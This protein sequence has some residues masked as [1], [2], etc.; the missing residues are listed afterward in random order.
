MLSG[1]KGPFVPEQTHTLVC[2][3]TYI[4]AHSLPVH[5]SRE[6]AKLNAHVACLRR[7]K[8]GRLSF[9][10][11]LIHQ[12]QGTVGELPRCHKVTSHFVSR[13]NEMNR[14][15]VRERAAGFLLFRHLKNLDVGQRHLA[16]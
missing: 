8:P 15:Q 12:G 6:Q 2:T 14:A 16:R 3:H 1:D 7:G 5:T 13:V 9:A 11:H 10:D 4:R